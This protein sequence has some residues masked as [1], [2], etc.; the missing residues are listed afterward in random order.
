MLTSFYHSYSNTSEA[1][2]LIANESEPKRIIMSL[3]RTFSI[4]Y[5]SFEAT[6]AAVAPP[7]CI[8]SASR[9][10]EHWIHEQGVVFLA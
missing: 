10:E 8:S 2:L 3:S 5:V 4:L 7:A 1:R 9:L 6:P